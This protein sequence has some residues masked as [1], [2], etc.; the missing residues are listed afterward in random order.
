M[1][2]ITGMGRSGT[3]VLSRFCYNMGYNVGGHWVNAVNAGMEDPEVQKVNDRLMTGEVSERDKRFIAEFPK[4]VVKDP[5]FAYPL[6]MQEWASRRL[7][8][9]VLML[10]RETRHSVASRK[11]HPQLHPYLE[12]V[13][14]MNQRITDTYRTLARFR[15][16]CRTLS[17][18]DFLTDYDRVRGLLTKFGGLTI[19]DERGRRSWTSLVDL[20]LVHHND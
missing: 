2:V 18:P 11:A 14:E 17:F 13:E 12:S 9:K 5:R 10:L 7:D 4:L 8:L 15:V 1:L 19:D 6:V 20:N 16:P 3:S